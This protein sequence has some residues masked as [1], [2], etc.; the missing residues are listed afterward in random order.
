MNAATFPHNAHQ[1]F[2]R[3]L[4]RRLGVLAALL[5][6]GGVLALNAWRETPVGRVR[7]R[8]VLGLNERPLAHVKVT[9]TSSE[10][11]DVE[12]DA[13]DNSSMRRIRTQTDE[14][15]EF[16]IARVAVGSYHLSAASRFHATKETTVFV[17]EDETSDAPL[18]LH[19]S[20]PDLQLTQQQKEYLPSEKITLPIHGYINGESE[21]NSAGHVRLTSHMTNAAANDAAGRDVLRVRIFRTSLRDV[22]RDTKAAA[23]FSQVG[24]RYSGVA[25]L[26]AALL[27]PVATTAP[28]LLASRVVPLDGADIE[29][30]FHKRLDL[31]RLGS[32]LY[33]VDVRHGNDSVC[34]RLTV[35]G[36]ALIV[37]KSRDALLAF[38]VDSKSG[39]PRPGALVQV[40]KDGRVRTE[41]KTDGQGLARIR[42]KSGEGG[43]GRLMTLA[44]YRADEATVGQ[45]DGEG[46]EN[47]AGG[48]WTVHVYTDR[49]LYRPGA[50]VSYKGIARRALDKGVRYQ[51]PQGETVDVEVRDASGGRVAKQVLKTNRFGSFHGSLALS[52]EAPTGTYSIVTTTRGEEHTDDFQVASYR[53]PE[54][55]ATVSPNE[56]H[57]ASGDTVEMFVDATYYFGAPVAGARVK[58]QILRAPDWASMYAEEPADNLDSDDD[59][60]HEYSY[61]EE[62]S[63][64]SGETVQE[65]ETTLDAQ[66][67]AII[68]F[69]AERDMKTD[70]E[71]SSGSDAA[72]A[73]LESQDQNYSVQATI[74]DASKR[75]VEA[76][77]S[78]PVTS[79]DFRLST[80]TPGFFAMPNQ[81]TPL[82]IVARDFNGKPVA[83][84]PLEISSSYREWDEKTR[85][86]RVTKAQTWRATTGVDGIATV[87]ITPAKEGEMW[88]QVQSRDGANRVISATRTLWVAGDEGGD[89][90]AQYS[91][92][93]LLTDKKRYKNGETARV[94]INSQNSGG[95]ALVTIEGSKLFRSWLV[96]LRHRSTALQVLMQADYGPNVSLSACLVRD[97]KFAQSDVPLR[98]DVPKRQVRVAIQSERHKYK[99]GEKATYQIQTSDAQGK[100]IACELSFGVVDESIYALRE[101]EPGALRSAFYPRNPNSVETGYSF[102]PLY[103]GDVNK[104]TPVIE[105]RRKFLDTAFWQPDVQTDASGRARVSFALP[106]NLTTWRATAVAQTL[107]TAFGRRTQKIVVAKDFFV[108]LETPRFFTGADNSQVTALIHNDT[109]T[110]QTATVQLQAEGMTLS[111]ATTQNIDIAPGQIAPLVWPVAV[112]NASTQADLKLSAWTTN[113]GGATYSDAVESTI[114]IRAHGRQ[115]VDFFAG[116]IESNAIATHQLALDKD[117]IP[118]ASEVTIRIT[119]SASDAMVG[120]LKYLVGFPYGCTEQTMSRFLPDILVQRTLRLRGAH[121][122]EAKRLALQLPQMA[123]DSLTRL[124]RFQH[125][126]GG[127]GWWQTDQDDAWMT[128]YVIYGLSL[129]RGEG[130]QI[131]ADMIANA[132]KA[133]LQLMK[134]DNKKAPAWQHE[135]WENTR[136]FT[137]YALALASPTKA[138]L[139]Q[140]RRIRATIST[141]AMDSQALGYLSLLDRKLN[142]SD[143]AR[144]SVKTDPVARF[145]GKSD[146][147]DDAWPELEKQLVYGDETNLHWKGSGREEWSDWNDVTA[148][149]LGLRAMIAHDPNDAR[150]ASVVLWLMTHR[151]GDKWSST[152]DTSWV[153]NALCDYLDSRPHQ[154]KAPSGTLQVLMGGASV[155][156]YEF[157]PQSSGEIVLRVSGEALRAAGGE[158]KLQR[159][160]EGAPIF[161]S[162]Q[163]RQTVASPV[164]LQKVETTIPIQITREY[165]RLVPH[166]SGGDRWSLQ[167]EA[168]DN[169]LR[170]G[171]RIRVR[172]S[173]N[174]PRPFSYVLIEDAFPA[175]C[176][177][178]ERG[179]ADVEAGEGNEDWNNWWSSSD[180]RDDRI[181]FFARRLSPG[182]HLIEYNLRAQTPGSYNALPAMLQAMYAPEVRGETSETQVT[183]R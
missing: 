134:R 164:P 138:E 127:W 92:L 81:A 16:E 77:G 135:N 38:A 57:Y 74:I 159:L 10:D 54:F 108:R 104:A 73:D 167:T 114:P 91:E 28:R 53:K 58:Y 44:S 150:I 176:E 47:E 165:R 93:S 67:H 80:R 131:D 177:T 61:A 154:T 13:G 36:T 63:D 163:V 142:S 8:V 76:S 48:Q 72:A 59:A 51:V 130:Y 37:K 171:D 2:S 30:F 100:P 144:L 168:T 65:G 111:G 157:K 180:V 146:G 133:A 161:Y 70:A 179:D 119:P 121:D 42:L 178:T 25:V 64:G 55:S 14:R 45:G 35:S 141:I 125:E 62:D 17:A 15:G 7:G 175:G 78:V 107:D 147:S 117:A 162:V 83:R 166:A 56:K 75:E 33:L 122:P 139:A 109:A 143:D 140:I 170:Q 88:L 129:A 29:G 99:P 123:R 132:R 145:A 169:Q 40:F 112:D 3:D 89:Y 120:A 101:D 153:L 173:F 19:R 49:P 155:A 79:G 6:A 18:E 50:R 41:A 31:G 69:K 5:F 66:G 110:A 39:E 106:D 102:E 71:D 158:L 97:K 26:P 95:S 126:S 160:G 84:A 116:Q 24:D 27:H 20:Q 96:P 87:Q 136:A 118:N 22:L 68:S 86:T 115:K 11:A 156:K 98:V 149:S 4:P 52:G 21:N 128:A 137:L 113:Q 182:R 60:A 172:L 151:Q 9:L 1:S 43:G 46:E 85:K 148:T 181:A 82:S 23:A 94:L 174:V 32:G 105:A 12:G 183:I 152:R 103:L 34:A 90:Q 124:Q